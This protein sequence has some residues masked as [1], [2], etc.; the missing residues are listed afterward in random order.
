MIEIRTKA[1]VQRKLG[2]HYQDIGG[3]ILAMIEASSLA[4]ADLSHRDLN[5]ADFQRADLR[6]TDFA[7]STLDFADLSHADLTG[8]CFRGTGLTCANL[9]G[10][11][12]D[13]A[14]LTDAFLVATRLQDADLRKARFQAAKWGRCY[15]NKST[16]WPEGFDPWEQGVGPSTK[17]EDKA[18]GWMAS[19]L[20]PEEYAAH[21]GHT[22]LIFGL[23]HHLFRDPV[24]TQWMH[25]LGEILANPQLLA[26]CQERFLSP[27]E[28]Q[29]IWRAEESE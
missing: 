26:E 2:D 12:L 3:E 14:D 10:S 16:R 4:G 25:R 6:E 19:G 17:L 11:V 8:A 23:T 1:N 18:M 24:L 29:A 21:H 13:D 20:T 15:F 5:F 9:R 22:I 28:R 7:G 27:E